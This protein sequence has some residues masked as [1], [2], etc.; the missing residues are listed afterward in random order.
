MTADAADIVNLQ[1]EMSLNDE[2]ENR[3]APMQMITRRRQTMMTGRDLQLP[4]PSP[5]KP[6]TVNVSHAN[7]AID[8]DNE[9][10][11]ENSF[12]VNSGAAG[13]AYR[14]R[15]ALKGGRRSSVGGDTNHTGDLSVGIV[16][17]GARASMGGNTAGKYV[18][19][20]SPKAAEFDK[21]APTNAITPLDPGG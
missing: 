5:A 11:T 2:S 10:F 20:G 1:R 13:R 12:T 3:T 6:R 14:P 9:D 8:N 19:F 16:E 17:P 7:R 4:S 21:E 18:M 15:S